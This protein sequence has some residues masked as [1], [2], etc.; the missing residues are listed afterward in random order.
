MFQLLRRGYGV[1]LALFLMVALLLG[2]GGAAGAALA[3]DAAFGDAVSHVMGQEGEVDLIVHLREETA[4]GSYP[5]LARLLQTRWPGVRLRRSVRVAGNDNVLVTFGPD[6]RR[7]D[8][9]E[10]LPALLSEITGYNGHT[11]VVEP[12]LTISG[13]RPAVAEQLRSELA[14]IPGVRF[15]FRHGSHVTLVLESPAAAETVA[16]RVEELLARYRV[17]EVRLPDHAAPQQVAEALW[18]ALSPEERERW[19]DLAAAGG[20]AT[21]TEAL[22]RDVA[23]LVD[24]Y[25]PRAYFSPDAGLAVGDR[26]VLPGESGHG[27]EP[28]SPLPQ[29]GYVLLEV[30]AAG[31]GRLLGRIV[32]GSTDYLARV[33]PGRYADVGYRVEGGRVGAPVGTVTVESVRDALQEAA[34]QAGRTVEHMES[35][36]GRLEAV[37]SAT[38]TTLSR[39]VDAL[40]QVEGAQRQI[41]GVQSLLGGGEEG[42]ASRHALLAMVLSS[43]AQEGR[44][45][46]DD[47]LA[48]VGSLAAGDGAGSGEGTGGGGATLDSVK[49]ELAELRRE[50]EAAFDPEAMAH[51]VASARRLQGSMPSLDDEAMIDALRRYDRYLGDRAG[52]GATMELLVPAEVSS[53]AVARRVAEAAGVAPLVADFEAGLLNPNPRASVL[54]ILA[55]VRQ[56]VAGIVALAAAAFALWADG[57]TL[58]HAGRLLDRLPG[59]FRARPTG[60]G[61]RGRVR[62][63]AAVLGWGAVLGLI[64]VAGMYH[65]AGGDIPGLSR[66]AVAALG[67]LMGAV[68]GAFAGRISPVKEE[69]LLAGA[70]CG[71]T[72][73]HIMREVV[74]PEGRPGFLMLV[75]RWRARTA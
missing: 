48:G 15:P 66:G 46:L 27:L 51:L 11:W 36:A 19:V 26:V 14:A 12:S 29:E 43:L 61:R 37:A 24:L 72:P 57:A 22:V 8:V 59:A 65:L 58:L 45:P 16:P 2:A 67:A 69:E 60:S 28:G 31:N 54:H 74:V 3:I 68:T 17:V 62:E 40:L 53:D 7:A 13:V 75:N 5:V 10:T 70:A 6:H 41:Q 49:A 30:T 50:V 73:A 32:R 18:N 63:R 25:A 4:D 64:L 20:A 39:W 21:G 52:W 1:D 34:A 55:Q 47:V 23:R 38:V 56:T 35:L 33:E 71:L 9:F 42:A 44:V